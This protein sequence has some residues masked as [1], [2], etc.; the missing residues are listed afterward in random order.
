MR[1]LK[2]LAIGLLALWPALASAQATSLALSGFEFD[3]S[4]AI[5][6]TADSLSVD[7]NTGVATF[8][9]NVII[10]QGSIRLSAGEVRVEYSDD[11]GA[12]ARFVASGGI[13][14]VT[15]SEAAEAE[16][17]NYDLTTGILV[18][19]GSVLLTMGASAL[20]ADVMTVS[21]NDG[22]ARLEGNVRTVLAPGGN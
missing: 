13:S 17:A 20:S 3:G 22:T 2:I 15:E 18:L 6:V 11:T 7:Q 10:G 14:F 19:S 12:I 5:E 9:G 8:I 16:S 21:L 1:S 4:A